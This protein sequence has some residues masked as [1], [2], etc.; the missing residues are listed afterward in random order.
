MPQLSTFKTDVYTPDRLVAG[1]PDDLIARQITL[2]SG[3]NLVRGAVLGK[4]TASSKYNQS[5]SAAADGSQTPD[6]ILAEDCDASGGDKV[7]IA[8]FTGMFNENAIGLGAAHTVASV[9]EGLRV[10]GIHL[11]PT[12]AA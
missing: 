9:R 5:L 8:Y 6:C 10:K 11:I 12:T 4:I 2:I 3:M 7:T 1:D